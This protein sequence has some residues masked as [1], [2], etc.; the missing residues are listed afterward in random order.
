MRKPKSIA[1]MRKRTCI[2]MATTATD[3]DDKALVRK[4]TMHELSA[5][6]HKLSNSHHAQA[7]KLFISYSCTSA[8]AILSHS[9]TST[10]AL[11]FL[12]RP[13]HD[14]NGNNTMAAI[15]S[16]VGVKSL[17]RWRTS[18]IFHCVLSSDSNSTLL[19]RQ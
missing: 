3:V 11:L 10:Q 6:A 16:Y 19:C 15:T 5:Q 4:C 8:Q 17:M 1:I 12:Y 2:N 18:F 13:M 9:C 7:H 14:G